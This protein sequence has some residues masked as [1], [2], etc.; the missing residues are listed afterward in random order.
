MATPSASTPCGSSFQPSA[1]TIS[2]SAISSLS[3]STMRAHFPLAATK[4]PPAVLVAGR[5]QGH[6]DRRAQPAL[7]VPEERCLIFEAVTV[8]IGQ[9]VDIAVVG[10]RDELAILAIAEVVDVGVVER[11]FADAETG[12]EHLDRRR[13]DNGY[14]RLAAGGRQRLR[15]K[16]LDIGVLGSEIRADLAGLGIG[17]HA[18]VDQHFD[19]VAG[20][21]ATHLLRAGAIRVE[22]S[23]QRELVHPQCRWRE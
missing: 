13:I 12:E 4:R 5:R 20:D 8:G 14:E 15:E 19:D 9:H 10:E 7:V 18:I 11:Q 6:A 1:M 17:E 22:T 16:P 23:P 21:W 3:V 2:L